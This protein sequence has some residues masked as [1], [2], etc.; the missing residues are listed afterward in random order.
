MASQTPASRSRARPSCRS[1]RTTRSD[2]TAAAFSQAGHRK[3]EMVVPGSTARNITCFGL[4]SR[5]CSVS[6]QK[7]RREIVPLWVNGTFHSIEGRYAIAGTGSAVIDLIF[8]IAKREVTFFSGTVA[9][10]F[11]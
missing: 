2:G 4:M 8:S 1:G 5:K 11:L 9:I 7:R 6:F 3:D 10:S